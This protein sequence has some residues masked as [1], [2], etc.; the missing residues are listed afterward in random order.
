MSKKLQLVCFAL[1]STLFLTAQDNQSKEYLSKYSGTE[2]PSDEWNEWFN[3]EVEKYKNTRGKAAIVSHTIPLIFHVVHF[4]QTLGTYPNIDSNQIKSQIAIL[5]N[6]FG[7]TGYNVGNVPQIFSNLVSNTGVQFC[8]ARKDPNNVTLVEHGI[9]RI[10]AA[11]NGFPDPSTTTLTMMA[12]IDTYIKPG[13]TWD[14]QR[15]MNIWICDKAAT[16][17]VNGFATWPAGTMVNG[18]PTP[19]G[20]ANNDGIWVW[21][22]K[23][24]DIGTITPGNRGRTLTKETGHWLGLRNIWGDGN[25]LTDYCEDTPWAKT[26]NY[27]CPVHPAFVNRCGQGQSPDGEMTMNFMDET[28][29]ACRYMFTPDQ[30]DRIQAAMSQCTFRNQ[31]GLHG[32]CTSPNLPALAPSAGFVIHGPPCVGRAFMPENMTTG[33]PV[34]TYQWNSAPTANFYPVDIVP[35]PAITFPA[36]GTYTLYLTATNSVNVSTFSMVV[37]PSNTCPIIP[38]CLDTLSQIKN[39]DTLTTYNSP[40]N[41]NSLNCNAGF[42]GYLAGTNCHKDKEFAQFYP[43]SMYTTVNNPQV[44]SVIVLFDSRGTKATASTSSTPITC[45]LYGGDAVNGPQSQF[46]TAT[47]SLGA[48]VNTANTTRTNTIKYCGSP[49]YTFTSN[50]IIPFKFDFT[51]PVPVTPGTAGFFAAVETPYLSPSDSI[52]IFTNTKTNT[53]TDSSSWVLVNLVN[54]WRTMRY[55][56]NAKVQLAILPQI[57]CRPWVGIEESSAFASNVNVMPNPNNGVFSLVFTMPV[58]T[59]LTVRIHN[60]IGQ[61]ISQDELENVTNN[62]VDIDLNGR[63]DGIYFVEVT[64]GLER[65][66][67]KVVITK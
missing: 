43:S 3:K 30:T 6:D 39:I 45:R 40:L 46:G 9:H 20:T 61:Q 2:V 17:T 23:I 12:Y 35:T 10:N 38:L 65:T 36:P 8:R 48:I 11:T 52:N 67:K 18:V 49:T 66:V 53:S 42:M 54:N 26:P 58:E 57:S 34:P 41:P 55:F 51:T 14:P 37:T 16:V 4:G 15:Y 56:R 29:D 44:N 33:F 50:R 22:R 59:K 19:G 1:L 63:P 5:N 60:A 25:C 31:L 64:S 47:A 62:V 27:G 24:G 32:L 13:N 28:D 7:G 21:T